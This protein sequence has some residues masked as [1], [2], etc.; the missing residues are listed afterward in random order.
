MMCSYTLLIIN[1]INVG[2]TEAYVVNESGPYLIC[3]GTHSEEVI[4][5]FVI[6][7]HSSKHCQFWVFEVHRQDLELPKL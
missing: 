2:E 7:T 6:F 4:Y 3:C 1:G 5:S